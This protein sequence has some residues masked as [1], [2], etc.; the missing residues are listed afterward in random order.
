MKVDDHGQRCAGLVVERQFQNPFHVV[1]IGSLPLDDRN[2][3][4]LPRIDLRVDVGNSLLPFFRQIVEEDAVSVII[5]ALWEKLQIFC[6]VQAQ[7]TS[8]NQYLD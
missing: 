7:T 4:Q 2:V 5:K 1:A 6:L 3:G 8:K